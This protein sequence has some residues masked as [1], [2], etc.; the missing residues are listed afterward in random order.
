MSG[1]W[2]EQ[3][4]R[5]LQGGEITR[6][7]ALALLKSSDDELLSVI[8]AAFELRRRFFGRRVNLHVLMNAKSGAC[9]EDCGFC[10]QS[11]V[12][13][14]P[15]EKYPL[16]TADEI[17]SGAAEAQG[18]GAMKYC[19]VIS[20]RSPTEMDLE[21]ICAAL[22]RIKT[23]FTS[24]HLC[25]SAGLLTESEARLLKAAG[26]D[27]IN[28]NL[29]TSRGFF[30][31]ICSTH[32]Y[33]DRVQT[34]RTAKAAGLEICCGGLVGLGESLGD[35]VDLAFALR[36]LGV[37][38]IPVNF[39]N[40]RAGTPLADAVRLP[41]G[42]ALRA[43]AMFRFV[44]PDTD[45]RAAGGREACLGSMQVLALYVANSIFTQG[46]LTTG[47]QGHSADMAMLERAGFTVGRIEA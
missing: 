8:G 6:Q 34:I 17:F 16:R 35:R 46:Y 31:R 36:E 14:A 32:S 40:P 30:P 20:G 29:E 4:G 47:G 43:L 3:A 19:T 5:V 11:A 1:A 21:T 2:D 23:A 45:I 22:R 25:V 33:E 15:I 41:A 9:G 7:E 42:D 18:L 44:N 13:A 37:H 27:R 38:S 24:L 26:A 10:S 12:S 39:F 28:H